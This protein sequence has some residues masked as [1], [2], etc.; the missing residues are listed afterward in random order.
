MNTKVLEKESFTYWNSDCLDIFKVA[1]KH[2][3]REEYYEEWDDLAYIIK[4]GKWRKFKE[5]LK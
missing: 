2:K 3:F 5:Y 4:T 1:Y